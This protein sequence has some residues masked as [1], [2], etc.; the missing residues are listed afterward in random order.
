MPWHLNLVTAGIL[1]AAAV[2]GERDFVLNQVGCP[3]DLGLEHIVL[4]RDCEFAARELAL[5][6]RTATRNFG[7]NRY[8]RPKFCTTPPAAAPLCIL[9]LPFISIYL[10]TPAPCPLTRGRSPASSVKL[11][12]DVSR[13]L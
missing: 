4:K 1:L 5:S 6:S 11:E 2:A 13:R 10:P 8:K 7:G 9:P 3:A 12:C